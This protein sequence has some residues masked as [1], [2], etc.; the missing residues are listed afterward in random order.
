MD[1]V[2]VIA[3]LGA[4]SISVER[5][6]EIIKSMVPF[7]AEES[8]DKNKE[9]YRRASLHLLAA[10]VGMVIAY[11]ARAQIQ[12]LLAPMFKSAE[13]LEIPSCIIIGLLASGGSGF[14]NQSMGIVEEIKQAKKLDIKKKKR[15]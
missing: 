1:I 7:L 15:K 3:L 11:I 12:P 2:S 4:L 14:W 6:V 9:R 5:V 8:R 13:V 10:I